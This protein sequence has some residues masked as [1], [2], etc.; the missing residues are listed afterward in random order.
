MIIGITLIIIAMI[1][2]SLDYYF[3]KIYKDKKSFKRATIVFLKH[4]IIVF[5]FS[6]IFFKLID[7]WLKNLFIYEFL[8]TKILSATVIYFIISLL[9]KWIFGRPNISFNSIKVMMISCLSNYMIRKNMKRLG[10][11]LKKMCIATVTYNIEVPKDK[12]KIYRQ[13][14]YTIFNRMQIFEND[15]LEFVY[16]TVKMDCNKINSKKYTSLTVNDIIRVNY[17]G[18][19]DRSSNKNFKYE[20]STKE[21]ELCKIYKIY[22]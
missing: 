5:I 22:K 14:Q 19:I 4:Y 17:N 16:F 7:Y 18:Y 13:K 1:I 12:Q 9:F 2:I 11:Y 20:Y 3:N 10:Y 15:K 8:L 21:K 6:Y